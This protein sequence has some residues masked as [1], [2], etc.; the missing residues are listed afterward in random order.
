MDELK[1]AIEKILK[2]GIGLVNQGVES[3]Q[4]AIEKLAEKGEPLYRQAKESVSDAAEKLK[5][6]YQGSSIPG[7]L[8][9][10]F[11]GKINTEAFRKAFS[12]MTKEELDALRALINEYYEAAP[13]EEEKAALVKGA[14]D[15]AE[16]QPE[17]KQEENGCESRNDD[18]P[19]A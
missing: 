7:S 16:E 11:N 12:Q 13:T 4:E 5:K 2:A 8:D 19:E 15:H 18:E 1:N 9:M 3:S 17:D 14:E 6:A 10:L